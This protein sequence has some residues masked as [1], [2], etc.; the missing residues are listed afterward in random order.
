MN[1]TVPADLR[2]KIKESEK[3]DNYLNL[4]RELETWIMRVTVIP[5]VFGALGM[6]PKVLDKGLKELGIR[7]RIE[8]I[9]TTAL[10]RM[11]EILRR[12]PETR[13]GLLSLKLQ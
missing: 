3:I 7:G 10:L 11:A 6:V 5:V 12:V 2:V 4:A 8:T 13:G 9:Q 1:F